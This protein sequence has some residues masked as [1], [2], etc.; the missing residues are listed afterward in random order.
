MKLAQ[1][2]V[3]GLIFELQK[4]L[5]EREGEGANF[6]TMLGVKANAAVSDI[7]KAP[8]KNT[9]VSGAAKRF[10]QLGL[11]HKI[12]R[13]ERRDRYNYFLTNGF[14]KWRGTGY[15]YERF[16]PGLA[17]VLAVLFVFSLV[18]QHLLQRMI[19][20]TDKARV[21]RL[22]RSA[23]A[24]AR[25]AW[26]QTPEPD[27]KTPKSKHAKP[28]AQKK[29]RVPLRG[30]PDL[31]PAPSNAEI[32]SGKVDW[33]DEGRKVRQ[34]M[35]AVHNAPDGDELRMVDVT[36]YAD[37]SMTVLDTAN[38]EWIPLEQ[39]DPAFAPSWST[40]WPARLLRFLFGRAA[41]EPV[42]T[43]VA[44]TATAETLGTDASAQASVPFKKA[45][46]RRARGSKN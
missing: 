42:P 7:R 29:V 41:R 4:A 37:N 35:S 38:D 2:L 43:E 5:V 28:P 33:D 40:L 31:S 15:F 17:L 13:D 1:L 30:Y 23:L 32:A 27:A 21:D 24:A 14:P 12:L 8:D 36:V 39:L 16:R 45:A 6:Y 19:W 25:G 22:Y 18:T 44:P 11:I 46:K 10:E 26:F 34:A 20:R 3:L 9:G